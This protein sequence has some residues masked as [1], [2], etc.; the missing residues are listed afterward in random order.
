MTSASQV[1]SYVLNKMN[2]FYRNKNQPHRC[3]GDSVGDLLR[4]IRNIGEHID[5]EQNQKQVIPAQ[6]QVQLRGA[7]GVA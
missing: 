1:D 2:N 3:Y 6:G 5:E 4:F 7:G